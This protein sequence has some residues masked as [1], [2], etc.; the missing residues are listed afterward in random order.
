MKNE[1]GVGVGD[2]VVPCVEPA[3]A[4]VHAAPGKQDLALIVYCN[5]H[6]DTGK[7]DPGDELLSAT[8]EHIGVNSVVSDPPQLKA[9]RQ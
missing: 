2:H 8:I 5:W 9:L 7:R 4:P 3:P 1:P 6:L